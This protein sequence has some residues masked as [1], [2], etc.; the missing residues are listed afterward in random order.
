MNILGN[1]PVNIK[2]SNEPIS[3][4]KIMKLC[5]SNLIERK[6]RKN[7]TKILLKLT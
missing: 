7:P 2:F 6:H 3:Y 5:N 4:R 1:G